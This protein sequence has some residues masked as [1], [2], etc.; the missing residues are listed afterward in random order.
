MVSVGKRERVAVSF[1]G[2][3]LL[4]PTVIFV[5]GFTSTRW[6][7]VEPC[8]V[9]GSDAEALFD[10]MSFFSCAEVL[11]QALKAVLLLVWLILLISLLAS[12]A[13][14]FFVPQLEQLALDLRL[15]EDVAGVT[16]LALG[17]GMPDVMTAT[18]SVN[19]AGDFSLTMG[20][21]FGAA[22]F[23]VSLVLA[24]V[25]LCSSGSTI[26]E[27][28]AFIRD[29]VSF[30]LVFCYM[31]F[32]TWDRSI[33]Q[34]ESIMFFIIYGLYVA[35][36]MVS[37]HWRLRRSLQARSDV[38]ELEVALETTELSPSLENCFNLMESDSE[39]APGEEEDRLEGLDTR[40]V[41]SLFGQLQCIME[42]PFTV[43]RH[44][45]IPAA[46]WNR[47]RRLLAAVCPA[48]A[49][50]V[51]LLAFGGWDAFHVTWGPLP[52][53][54]CL[55]LIGAS[56]AVIVFLGSAPDIRPCWHTL[57]L[58]VSMASTMSWFNLLANECVAVLETFGIKF[59][60]SS[61]ILGI[62]VLAWGNSV[63]DLVADTAL[64]RQG[65]SK[66]AVAGCFGSPLLSDL[67]GLGVALTSYTTTNGSLKAHLSTQNKIAA[68]FL[69]LSLASSIFTFV[70]FRFACPRWY[71]YVLLAQYSA[72]M[73]GSVLAEGL[74]HS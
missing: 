6:T 7:Y 2:V 41:E 32:V 12:T 4:V 34:G 8:D 51:G 57:L 11:P 29:S 13:D 52:E 73:V 33:T 43:L 23:I 50:P 72:F 25:I 3:L 10:Y 44:L 26:V 65:K 17:N 36:V 20:E 48:C 49:I 31:I 37:T 58:L 74:H 35:V 67:L 60:I 18:S 55:M 19:K 69:A 5:L 68:G 16:L 15:T 28:V 22:N 66:M 24:C 71:A 21:F 47:N 39:A 30:A 59:G 38:R 40:A 54:L 27:P 62:T 61:S 64:A 14:F 9:P 1:L 56:L 70:N 45:T 46:K 63:G 53:W 42:L